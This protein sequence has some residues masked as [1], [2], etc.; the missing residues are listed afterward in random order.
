[1]P[2]YG[3]NDGDGVVRTV[4][5]SKAGVRNKRRKLDIASLRE[6]VDEGLVES[7][8]HVETH[9]MVADGLTKGQAA[10]KGPCALHD[11]RG[12]TNPT[13]STMRW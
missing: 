3:Y 4:N 7:F 2:V 9:E 8:E 13:N 12:N 11:T 6:A 1:M 5:T 10:L